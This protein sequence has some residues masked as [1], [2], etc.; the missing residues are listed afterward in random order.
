MRVKERLR[1]TEA[2]KAL[3]RSY[4]STPLRQLSVKASGGEANLPRSHCQADKLERRSMEVH[5][6]PNEE[7]VAGAAVAAQILRSGWNKGKR[8]AKLN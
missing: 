3:G 5:Q 2:Q 7:V 8:L 6:E 1:Q 4:N